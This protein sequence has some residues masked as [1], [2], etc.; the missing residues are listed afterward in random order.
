M[1]ATRYSPQE[2]FNLS[3]GTA[4][5]ALSL[6]EI[7]NISDGSAYPTEYTFQEVL[8]LNLGVHGT[9][10][11]EQEALFR[12]LQDDLSLTDPY[13]K[14]SVQEM[15]NMAY[16]GEVTVEETLDDAPPTS[17]L[18]ME[19]GDALLAENGNTLIMEG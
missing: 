1:P 9:M 12:T 8:N 13:T 11:S 10:Y 15:L 18:L 17:A 6:Q 4:P 7:A 2:A 5:T 16:D 14:Y 19:S 3:N